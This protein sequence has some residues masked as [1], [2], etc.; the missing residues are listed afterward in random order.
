[1]VVMLVVVVR[2]VVGVVLVVQPRTKGVVMEVMVIVMLDA[3]DE[4]GNG[5]DISYGGCGGVLMII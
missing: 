3:S 4:Y 5:G 2:V 1:M